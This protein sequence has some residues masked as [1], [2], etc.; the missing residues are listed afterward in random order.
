MVDGSDTKPLQTGRPVNV[1]FTITND[2]DSVLSAIT[3]DLLFEGDPLCSLVQQ[4][5]TGALPIGQT[6]TITCQFTPV[7]GLPAYRVTNGLAQEIVI[8]IEATNATGQRVSSS[9]RQAPVE[10]AVQE[11]PDSDIVHLVDL[12]LGVQERHA[13]WNGEPGPA[14]RCHQ[15]RNQPDES[16]RVAAWLPGHCV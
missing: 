8:A 6:R 3:F 14:E 10:E 5:G 9:S 7:P 16:G 4:D 15:D 11:Q 2:S 12:K 13:G 1:T